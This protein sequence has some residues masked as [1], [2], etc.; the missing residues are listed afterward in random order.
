MQAGE[1]T[2][3]KLL[4]T[5]RQFIVPIFQRHYSWHFQ[6]YEQLW[7]DI[8]RAGNFSEGQN[9]FMGSIVYMDL[10]T[11]AGRP[12]QLLL[13]DGQQRLTTIS[14]LIHAL[15]SYIQSKAIS[16]DLIN[17]AKLDNQFLYN[18]DELNDDK[19]KLILNE[20]DKDTYIRLLD[21]DLLTLRNPS[22]RIVDCYN[23]FWG[24][25]DEHFKLTANLDDIYVGILNL[26]VV[27]IS[28]TKN[29]DNPQLI[30]ESMNSTGKD[31]SQI[32]LLRNYLLMDSVPEEQNRLYEIYWKPLESLF[33]DEA[34]FISFIR[35]YLTIKRDGQICKIKD[36]YEVFKRYTV[37]NHILR[38][39]LLKDL[40]RYA[41]FYANMD[42]LKEV[43]EELKLYWQELKFF[44]IKSVYPFFLQLYCTYSNQKINKAD[45]IFAIKLT[46][47]YLCRRAICGIPTNS[48]SKIF[49]NLYKK[50][51]FNSYRNSLIKAYI[52]E[53]DYR[54]FPSDYEVRECLQTKDMYH[55][56][57]KYYI[58]LKIEN[59]QHKELIDLSARQYTVEHILPQNIDKNPSWQAILGANW[60]EVHA[61][62]VNTLGNLTLTGYNSE[63]GNKSFEYK[64]H[65]SIGFAKS[66]LK[67][68]RMIAEYSVW[69]KQ[70]IQWRTNKLTDVL[71]KLWEYPNL[72]YK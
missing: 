16:M 47:N 7:I 62:Y 53:P 67:I 11:P 2:L 52:Y 46:I 41:I 66:H 56:Y 36:V 1:T 9:H 71:L 38:E 65:S 60:Q 32:D 34:D 45:F 49:A 25:I 57:L 33:F 14:I 29:I 51:D 37:N 68:N 27:S 43:D 21:G 61:L 28:L 15:K 63:M 19:Y 64:V 4:N 22:R 72:C 59:C 26:N 30:F 50:I 12:Q 10:G 70:S 6:Q 20:R 48:L 17:I 54:R 18:R 31:L 24:K 5:T 35:D 40:Y 8:L 39:D 13:I 44:E 55:F 3:N 23:Y 58:L 69:N 42:L